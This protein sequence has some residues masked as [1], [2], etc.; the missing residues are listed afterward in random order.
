M[1]N[2]KIMIEV[3]KDLIVKQIVEGLKEEQEEQEEREE[4]Q[5]MKNNKVVTKIKI[6]II[7]IAKAIM[8]VI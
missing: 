7:A 6:F 3:M 1:T 2:C 5:Q 4:Q 8:E